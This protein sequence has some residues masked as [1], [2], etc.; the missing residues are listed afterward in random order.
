MKI[1]TDKPLVIEVHGTRFKLF[2]NHEPQRIKVLKSN[3]GVKYESFNN[4]KTIF[5]LR[6]A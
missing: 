4:G 2:P 5:E 6:E 3:K 1:T